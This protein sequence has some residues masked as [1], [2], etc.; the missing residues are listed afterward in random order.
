MVTAGCA[1]VCG[2]AQQREHGQENGL[3]ARLIGEP[4]GELGTALPL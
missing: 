2:A 3:T 1:T 4:A